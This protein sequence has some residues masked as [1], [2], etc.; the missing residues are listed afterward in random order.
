MAVKPIIHGLNAMS[1]QEDNTISFSY[2]GGL[3]KKVMIKVISALDNIVIYGAGDEGDDKTITTAKTE[4]TIPSNSINVNLYGTQYYIQIKVIENNNTESPWSDS[5][6]AIFI[7][8]PEFEFANAAGDDDNPMLVDNSYLDVILSYTQ[9]ENELLQEYKF[10]LYNSVKSLISSTEN[11][12]D[13]DNM[14]YRFNGFEDG[15]YY[16]RATGNTIHNYA[17]D[18]GLIKISVDYVTPES[19]SIFYLDNNYKGGYISYYTNIVSIDYYGDDTFEFE[20]GYIDLT[21]PNK[22]LY[23]DRGFNIKDNCTFKIKGKDLY[24]SN[25][26]FFEA[27]EEN[28]KY[29]FY[30]TSYIYDDDTI[31]YKLIALNGMNKYVLYSPSIP[32]LLPEDLVTFFV[33]KYNDVFLFI[34]F[35]NGVEVM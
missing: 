20:N 8:T 16:I 28:L 5:V 21:D 29:G 10:Y 11:F 27:Y 7:N 25:V 34:V 35:V 22:K 1:W 13:V 14:S 2:S 33:R 4:Y 23:Y 18:T 6:F 24:R 30:I 19:Y 31:R 9:N 26:I 12:Y 15:I 3:I 17:V 32:P